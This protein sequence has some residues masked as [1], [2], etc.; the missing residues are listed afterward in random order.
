VRKSTPSEFMAL[1]ADGA[2]GRSVEAAMTVTDPLRIED[3]ADVRSDDA[4]LSASASGPRWLL[5]VWETA[6]ALGVGRSTVYELINAGEL[7]VVHIGR[8]CRVPIVAVE[9]YV[10]R[11]R[12][13]QAQAGSP[14]DPTRNRAGVSKRR[15]RSE[16]GRTRST[17]ASG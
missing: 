10:E 9:A 1:D 15:G 4:T 13:A 8:A 12:R 2:A 17:S 14:S 7:E 11:L 3:A 5:T 6:R 16:G